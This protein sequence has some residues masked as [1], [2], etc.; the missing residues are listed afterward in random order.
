MP[1][2]YG[3]H[4]KQIRVKKGIKATYVAY[5]LKVSKASYSDI[6]SGKRGLSAERLRDIV[7]VIGCSMP[8]L[9]L[10]VYSSRRDSDRLGRNKRRR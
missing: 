5:R 8:E 7:C 2:I 9:E 6:E 10:L 4:I 1:N 3:P